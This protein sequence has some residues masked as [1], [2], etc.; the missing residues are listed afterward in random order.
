MFLRIRLFSC[1]G[2]GRDFSEPSL[3]GIIASASS[4][5]RPPY[6]VEIKPLLVATI[7]RLPQRTID[8]TRPT[9]GTVSPRFTLQMPFGPSKTA[10][11]LVT[12]RSIQ[13]SMVVGLVSGTGVRFDRECRG[14]DDVFDLV[15]CSTTLRR[16]DI[17]V[18]LSLLGS[19]LLCG[20]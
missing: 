14:G 20:V 9:P 2:R 12:S 15:L 16:S 11:P 1:D 10:V 4:N 18:H 7:H 5:K 8:S 3:S 19:G 13:P 17:G 6:G